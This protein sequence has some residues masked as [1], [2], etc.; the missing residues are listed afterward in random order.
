MRFANLASP[1]P[2][3][4]VVEFQILSS[5]LT[6]IIRYRQLTFY[7]FPWLAQSVTCAKNANLVHQ[8]SKL[9]NTI[10]R[11]ASFS[12][13][14]PSTS[15]PLKSASSNISSTA[16]SHTFSLNALNSHYNTSTNPTSLLLRQGVI[17][18]IL[19]NDV[20]KS[21]GITSQAPQRHLLPFVQGPKH[22]HIPNDNGTIHGTIP[23]PILR[24][25]P[26]R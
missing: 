1:F 17:Y 9:L 13:S 10:L 12:S 19:H 20:Q 6:I 21:K 2:H 26:L 24:C 16:L 5:Q 11:L 7:A 15:T 18:S 23:W 3:A 8:L 4:A 25:R 22:S 14:S